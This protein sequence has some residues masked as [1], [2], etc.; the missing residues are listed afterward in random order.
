MYRFTLL[1]RKF[2]KKDI[3]SKTVIAEKSNPKVNV[4]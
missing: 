4:Q 1:Q 3:N 2:R